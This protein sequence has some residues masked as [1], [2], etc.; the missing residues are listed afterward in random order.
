LKDQV[1]VL[2]PNG[3]NKDISPYELPDDKWSDGT[4]VS[5]LNDK[6]SKA[7]GYSEFASTTTVEP[8][9]LMPFNTL[10]D[11]YWIYAGLEKIY[12][13]DGT[14]H[15]NITRQTAAEDADYATTDGKWNGGV[16]GGVAILNN[17]IDVPQMFGTGSTI[18]EDLDYWPTGM[19]A[20]V[21]RPFKQFLVALDTTEAANRYP[22][23]VHWS[24]PAEPGTVPTTWNAALADKDAGYVDL[25]QTNGWVVDALPLKDANIIYKE[26]SV[27]GMSYEGGQSIF[28]FYE[29]FNDAGVFGQRC[30][31]SFDEKHFV[32]T[33]NDVYVHNGQTKESVITN[34]MRTEL[35]NSMNADYTHKTFVTADYR[36]NEMWICIVSS[37][38]N[39][40]PA[41]YYAGA[42]A[43]IAPLPDKAFIWNWKNNTWTTRDIPNV[44]HIGWGVV[45]EAQGILDWTDTETWDSD[46][47]T[48]DYRGY[49]PAETFLLMVDTVDKK[50][51]K[52]DSTEYTFDG[53]D[54]KAWVR[55]D[56]MNLGY[57]G[58]KSLKKIIPK[59]SGTGTVDIYIGQ[60]MSPG[61]SITWSPLYNFRIGEQ[62]ELPV[63]ITGNYLSVFIGSND[64]N[65]WALDNLELHWAPSGNRGSGT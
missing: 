57:S 14:T 23:R 31:K 12:K 50:L 16:L 1:K 62:S 9:W 61:S 42:V 35:F 11:S 6:T 53:T 24:H 45:T 21:I 7:I 10:S 28:R 39:K 17:G 22:Y 52:V 30:V 65:H 48:W 4:N 25:S 20:S 54:Y 19:K 5:F 32:L 63:R 37:G 58:T 18:C 64:S 49:N 46:G 47:S 41:S 51:F 15:T 36:N 27:W 2:N 34:Q 56:S 55:K 40:H 59:F 13:V 33:T 44:N 8:Y 29:I 3:I 38:N 26:D 60:S 43:D